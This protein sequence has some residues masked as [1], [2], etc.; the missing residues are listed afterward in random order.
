MESSSQ[1]PLKSDIVRPLVTDSDPVIACAPF[2]S[3]ITS[4]TSLIH[5]VIYLPVLSSIHP[6]ILPSPPHPHQSSGAVCQPSMSVHL[7]TC[8]CVLLV[9]ACVHVSGQQLYV[10]AVP[11]ASRIMLLIESVSQCAMESSDWSHAAQ[12]VMGKTDM[13]LWWADGGSGEEKDQ[14]LWNLDQDYSKWRTFVWKKGKYCA[15]KKLF[16]MMVCNG[17][18]VHVDWWTVCSGCTLLL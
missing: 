13:V 18:V 3:S 5:P 2:T 6:S 4:V 9:H 16:N 7:C 1:Q 15:M 8:V 17:C 12:L 11:P 10:M 14:H